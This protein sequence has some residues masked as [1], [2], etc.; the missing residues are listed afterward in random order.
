M[1]A[2]GI[3]FSIMEILKAGIGFIV[4]GI[5]GS[6][7]DQGLS[8]AIPRCERDQRKFKDESSSPKPIPCYDE[9]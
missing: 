1:P 5:K 4:I 2:T 3:S 9:L 7:K 6:E 8:N